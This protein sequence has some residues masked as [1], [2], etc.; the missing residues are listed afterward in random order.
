METPEFTEVAEKNL[1]RWVPAC[2]G[3]ETVF[4]S[5]S[6]IRMLYCWNPKQGHAYL[7]VDTDTIMTPQEAAA[8]MQM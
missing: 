6:G 2:G 4:K 3:T 1:D 5:R 7:N 8:A